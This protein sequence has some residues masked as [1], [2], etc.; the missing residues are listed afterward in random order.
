MHNKYFS[1][2]NHWF[3]GLVP[4]LKNL[5]TAHNPLVFPPPEILKLDCSGII[6][7]LRK[8]WNKLHQDEKV[9]IEEIPYGIG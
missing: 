1:L 8:E 4:N 3:A 5:Q 6:N 9:D 2:H 7:F